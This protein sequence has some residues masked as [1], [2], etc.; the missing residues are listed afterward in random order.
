[1]L[2]LLFASHVKIYQLKIDMEQGGE[3]G[4][5]MIAEKYEIS[6]EN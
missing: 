6:T 4:K 3:S 5:R 1:M 2:N